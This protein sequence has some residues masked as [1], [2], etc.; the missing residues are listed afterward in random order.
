[1]RSDEWTVLQYDCCHE[2]RG[3]GPR[4]AQREEREDTEKTANDKSRREAS[5]TSLVVQW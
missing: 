4:H 5:R 2:E 1:M 3:S